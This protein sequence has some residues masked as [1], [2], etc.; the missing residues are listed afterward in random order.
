MR[1]DPNLRWLN[2][3]DTLDT[4]NIR[5]DSERGAWKIND[6]LVLWSGLEPFDISLCDNIGLRNTFKNS[7]VNSIR[8]CDLSDLYPPFK[9]YKRSESDTLHV[10]K[11][12]NLIFFKFPEH[13]CKEPTWKDLY[14]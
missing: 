8:D 14:W 10:I 9:V 4:L 13:L 12:E 3:K 6:S 5:R 11:N 7:S 1:G 2:C